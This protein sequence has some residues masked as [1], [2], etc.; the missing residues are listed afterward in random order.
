MA[1]KLLVF[2]PLLSLI[3]VSIAVEGSHIPRAHVQRVKRGLDST[4]APQLSFAA[5]PEHPGKPVLV[6]AQVNQFAPPASHHSQGP[7]KEEDPKE[8][9]GVSRKKFVHVMHELGLH[10][11]QHQIDKLYGFVSKSH[12]DGTPPEHEHHHK[13]DDEK[14]SAPDNGGGSV[15][16]AWKE[17]GSPHID[18]GGQ[19][20]VGKPKPL[21]AHL[22]MLPPGLSKPRP[23][24]DESPPG[25]CRGGNEVGVQMFECAPFSH[26]HPLL[27]T[28]HTFAFHLHSLCMASWIVAE[29]QV[30]RKRSENQR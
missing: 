8:E 5:D 10:P 13:H 1:R 29:A 28:Y 23:W 6:E 21:P 2:L 3:F 30:R 11:S 7:K 19:A 9:G 24:S 17:V 4:D 27:V 26:Y 15:K 14:K 18:G 22:G 25:R 12:H 20:D 16:P